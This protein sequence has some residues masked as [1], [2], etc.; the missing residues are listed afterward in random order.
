MGIFIYREE[1][2]TFGCMM[3][4][5]SKT[6]VALRLKLTPTGYTLHPKECKN[7]KKWQTHPNTQEMFKSVHGFNF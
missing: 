4:K 5:M 7:L 6:L 2:V 3:C 1:V